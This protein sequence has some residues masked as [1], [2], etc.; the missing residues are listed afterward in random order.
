MTEK[1]IVKDFLK[2]ARRK[3]WGS[4]SL[5]LLIF[6][7]CGQETKW[8]GVLSPDQVATKLYPSTSASG[9]QD[10]CQPVTLRFLNDTNQ[11]ARILA[12]STVTLGASAGSY[13]SDSACTASAT[14]VSAAKY[15][16]EATAYFKL[17]A[18]TANLTA[19][20]TNLAAGTASVTIAS[21]SANLVLG[22]PNFTSSAV[23]NGGLSS[24]SMNAMY[25]AFVASDKLFVADSSNNRVLIW[26]SLPTTNGQ[27]ADIV[28]GQPD[29]NSNASNNGGVSAQ[30]MAKPS[31]VY[32]DGTRLVVA[33]EG[34][35]R[36][37]IWNSIPTV[38]HKAA[39]VVLGQ[40]NM[41]SA[42]PNNGG[43]GAGTLWGPQGV[44]ISGGKLFVADYFNCRILIWNSV[45]S[46]NGTA[47][48][49]VLGQPNMTTNAC[50]GP[51]ATAFVGVT[52]L[53]V[54]G[55]KFFAVDFDGNRV[56]LWNS[57]P[58]SNAIPADVI[59]GQPDATSG[60]ANN[61][62]I[63]AKTFDGPSAVQVDSQGRFYVSDFNNSRILIWNRIPSSTFAAAD[64][65]AGQPD[66]VSSAGNN[67]G[68]GAITIDG[69]SSVNV[70]G[71]NMWIAD[72]NNN[73][74]LKLPTP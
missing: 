56:M 22:Q 55:G 14:S 62:G 74:V 25:H 57:I 70:S 42:A 20:T 24:Q 32:S 2:R 5:F 60:A 50:A 53:G 40:P 64:A 44:L 72:Y 73:R 1:R 71:S 27:A 18:G 35:H 65:V 38:S 37:L 68:I 43:V 33:E 31:F 34:N 9:W 49:S 4:L 36:V 28:L 48:D 21:P 58:S 39:D 66:F 61:G 11:S 7:S 3:L 51:T 29:M 16:T 46:V 10:L 67:G 54:S 8:S 69:A 19:A 12:D 63:S 17:N 30:S 47:A 41:T 15:A 6:V 23:N 45:P 13:Y 52:N 59:L 26:N